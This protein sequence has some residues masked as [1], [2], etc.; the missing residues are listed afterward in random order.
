MTNK[1]LEYINGEFDSLINGLYYG[2][3]KSRLIEN[4]L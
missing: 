1:T 4:K 3:N 2:S